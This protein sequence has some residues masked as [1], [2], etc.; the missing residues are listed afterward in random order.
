MK[1]FLPFILVLL[2]S[3]CFS[4]KNNDFLKIIKDERGIVV[5]EIP[6][7]VNDFGDTIKLGTAKFYKEGNIR[8]IVTYKNNEQH[9]PVSRYINNQLISKGSFKFGKQDG[10][11]TWYYENGNIESESYWV[12]GNKYGLTKYYF[13]NKK[14]KGLNIIDFDSKG[15][16]LSTWDSAGNKIIND[17]KVFSENLKFEWIDSIG[18]EKNRFSVNHFVNKDSLPINKPICLLITVSQLP[19]TKQNIRIILQDTQGII[20]KSEVLNIENCTAA[21]ENIFTDPGQYSLTIKGELIDQYGNT[22]K[23]DQLNSLITVLQ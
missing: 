13:E 12:E 7:H 23:S 18:T 3:C 16:W 10:W 20:L 2:F 8:D 5:A 22:I 17:G 21:W 19:K 15:V 1:T 14:L 9:G 11:S 4:K 6:Y